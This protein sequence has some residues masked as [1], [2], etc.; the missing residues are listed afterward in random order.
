V[1]WLGVDRAAST[2]SK[3]SKIN[4]LLGLEVKGKSIRKPQAC[5]CCRLPLMLGLGC[6]DDQEHLLGSKRRPSACVRTLC[7]AIVA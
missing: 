3:A 4:K 2:M 7:F 5:V 1:L 6:R